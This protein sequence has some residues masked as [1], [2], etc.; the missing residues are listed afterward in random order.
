MRLPADAVL[1]VIDG[2]ETAGAA[3]DNPD[4]AAAIADLVQAWRTE[5]L[6]VFHVRPE[7]SAPGSRLIGDNR[8]GEGETQIETRATSAFSGANLE[9]ALDALGATTL[10][11]CGAPT[12]GAVEATAR[13]AGDLG[14]QVFVVAD[15]CWA[16]PVRDLSG[17]LWSAED[18]H[19]LSLSHLKT[20]YATIVDLGAALSA[21]SLAKAR[22][23][24]AGKR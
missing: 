1:I 22:Q 24:R 15:A 4:A 8:L 7:G 19:T 16:E 6:P 9:E 10:V 11:I 23:R 21:A 18:V 17:R 5:G 12:P 14:Y 20:R 3:P 13:H 2:L